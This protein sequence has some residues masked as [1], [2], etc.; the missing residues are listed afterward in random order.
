MPDYRTC[1]RGDS[2]AVLRSFSFSAADDDQAVEKSGS[3]DGARVEVWQG[4]R[5]VKR[6]EQTLA[7]SRFPRKRF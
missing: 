5:L 7:V 6:I 3:V 4:E 2:G 1:V